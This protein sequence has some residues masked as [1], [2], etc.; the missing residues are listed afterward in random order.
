MQ[1]YTQLAGKESS[2][3]N[4]MGRKETIIWPPHVPLMSYCA[5]A[6]ALL[7]TISLRGSVV[8]SNSHRSRKRT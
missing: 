1:Q 5:V 4:A 3:G 8:P 2:D 7:L 6:G